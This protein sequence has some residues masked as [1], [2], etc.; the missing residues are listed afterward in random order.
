MG[1]GVW[2]EMGVVGWVEEGRGGEGR[3]G[4]GGLKKPSVSTSVY[5]FDV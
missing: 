4:G 1:C 5:N 3:G 2:G